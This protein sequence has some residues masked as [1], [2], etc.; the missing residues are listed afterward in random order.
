MAKWPDILHGLRDC[1]TVKTFRKSTIRWGLALTVAAT[2]I[3]VASFAVYSS[4]QNRLSD[5]AC[6]GGVFGSL[7]NMF[8][9]AVVMIWA[10]S[11][12]VKSRNRATWHDGLKPLNCV[13]VSSVV[14]IVIGLNAAR[15]C[16][17]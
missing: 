4:G 9:L 12:A 6:I 17:V 11:L 16:T 7:A 8:I 14:A 10:I 5:G 2:Q 3:A 1:D 15:L 13:A